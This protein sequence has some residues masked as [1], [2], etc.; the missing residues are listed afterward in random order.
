M[1]LRNEKPLDEITKKRFT[2][3]TSICDY[4]IKMFKEHPNKLKQRDSEAYDII[5][6]YEL[7]DGT[8]R[9]IHRLHIAMALKY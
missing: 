1:C 2:Y 5:S 6:K 4:F 8:R 7:Y 9:N 3:I